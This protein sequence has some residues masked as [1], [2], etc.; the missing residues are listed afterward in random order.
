MK[1]EPS[2]QQIAELFQLATPE[3]SSA[4]PKAR[5]AKGD[6]AEESAELG[7]QCLGDGNYAK[8]VEHFKT[9]IAQR[10]PK[11]PLGHLD[12]GG[13]YECMDEAPQA[14]RQYEKAIKIRRDQPEPWVGMADLYK[15]YGRY[16]DSIERLQAAIELEPGNAFYHIKL[17]ELFRDMG[18]PRRALLAAQGAVAASP[19]EPFYH[20]W[21][22]DLL[23]QMGRDEEALESLRAA[24]EMS[25]GDDFLYLR[26]TVA[27][28]NVGRHQEA[29][30]ALRLA[31]DLDP[32]KNVY[33]GLLEVLLGKMELM[34][35]ATLERDRAARMDSYDRDLL[36]RLLDEMKFDKPYTV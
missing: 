14:L 27:F 33:H 28:W 8:A 30:K 3:E 35:E 23:I 20:Y 1:M 25:P 29:L 18:E 11:D 2:F 5:K 26:A 7:K 24:I 31:S 12:L 21:V 19:E 17:A 36:R 22:G 10:D 32:S 6:T 15:R 16:K 4:A 9:A 34:D 13:A